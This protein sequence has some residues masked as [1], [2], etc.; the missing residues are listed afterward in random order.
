MDYDLEIQF[1]NIRVSKVLKLQ[2]LRDKAIES[3]R[4]RYSSDAE[5]VALGFAL[6][7]SISG[8][9]L[10]RMVPMEVSGHSVSS[11]IFRSCVKPQRGQD[12]AEDALTVSRFCAALSSDISEYLK[13]HPKQV[14]TVVD[15]VRAEL[16]FPHNYYVEGLDKKAQDECVVWL[17]EH[18]KIMKK[19]TGGK[20]RELSLKATAYFAA[21]SA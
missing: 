12:V 3:F 13:R 17:M 4:Q 11:E 2:E 7:L 21:Q 19:V 1:A 10:D 20:W 18:D 8:S 9:N 16:S 5:E 15:G 6:K 14:R